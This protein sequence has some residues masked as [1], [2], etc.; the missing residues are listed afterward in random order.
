MHPSLRSGALSSHKEMEDEAD[1]RLRG[2]EMEDNPFPIVFPTD[3][4]MDAMYEAHCREMA[5]RQL[6]GAPD[7]EQEEA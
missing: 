6:F 5:L 3:E 7:C 4:E 2:I 1:E